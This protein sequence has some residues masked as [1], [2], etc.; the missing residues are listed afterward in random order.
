MG[1]QVS[2]VRIA[3]S[4]GKVMRINLKCG[5][6]QKDEAKAL[7]ARWDAGRKTWYIKDVED[8]TPFMQWIPSDFFHLEAERKSAKAEAKR[9]R[10]PNQSNGRHAPRTTG[11]YM[12]LCDC[13][14][15]PW[16]DCEHTEELA[17][18]AMRGMLSMD[19]AIAH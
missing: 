7:G 19:S 15:L 5:F 10:H 3:T 8:L 2:R 1:R 17:A 4:I 9:V 18:R 12:P 13:A 6:S 14:E 16:D 11:K